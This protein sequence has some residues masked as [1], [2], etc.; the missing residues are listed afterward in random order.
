M[1]L[2][3]ERAG[4]VSGGGCFGVSAGAPDFEAFQQLG[5]PHQPFGAQEGDGEGG[6]SD[7]A[8]AVDQSLV[9]RRS[10]RSKRQCDG[11][12]SELELSVAARGLG[13][14]FALRRGARD[15]LDL[16]R[17]EAKALIDQGRL[18][19]DGSVIGQED[20]GRAAFEQRGRDRR[21]FD[22]RQRLGGEYH[23]HILLPERLQPFADARG[24]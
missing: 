4:A 14:V 21:T 17:I 3:S 8:A 10:G 18:R 9:L 24:K 12:K 15:D 11:A 7:A 5:R 1:T 13:I 2:R 20:P 6:G 19:L 16:S 23:R 22:I